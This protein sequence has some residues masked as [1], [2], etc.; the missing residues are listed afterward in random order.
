MDLSLSFPEG[1]LK[2]ISSPVD[3][4]PILVVIGITVTVALLLRGRTPSY[5]V[6]VFFWPSVMIGAYL[7]LIVSERW[8]LFLIALVIGISAIA[9]WKGFKD[10]SMSAYLVGVALMGG[11]F[12]AGVLFGRGGEMIS[13][14]EGGSGVAPFI[15]WEDPGG[16]MGTPFSG[17]GTFVLIILVGGIIAFLLFQRVIPIIRSSPAKRKEENELE[18]QLSSTVDSAMTKLREGKDIHSTIL[19]CYQ[20]MCF[21]L[22]KEGAKNFEFMTPREFEKQAIRTLDVSTSK[23]SEIREVFE[24]A[25]YS[26]YQL[27]EEDRDKA[28][29]AL[30]DL[31]KELR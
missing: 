27:G 22:E 12:L 21:T 1:G 28:L 2:T 5:I 4:W 18:D 9:F 8:S 31:R 19:R 14:D 20:R 10:D 26:G 25:K 11:L 13:G 17:I 29:T 16:Y 15:S 3:F 6:V 7:L 23:I 30:K 24:L